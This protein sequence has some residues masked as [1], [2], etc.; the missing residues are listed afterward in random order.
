MD[1]TATVQH[2]EVIEDQDEDGWHQ[3]WELTGVSLTG[4][5]IRWPGEIGFFLCDASEDEMKSCDVHEYSQLD[6]F[7]SQRMETH[8]FW[9]I[10]FDEADDAIKAALDMKHGG[11]RGYMADCVPA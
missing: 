3:S 10:F 5:V 11:V 8:K 6:G 4:A 2:V 1:L 7:V 9:T